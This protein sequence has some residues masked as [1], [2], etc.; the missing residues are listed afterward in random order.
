MV[1]DEYAT[2][3]PA[4]ALRPF[5]ARYTGYRQRGLSPSRHRGLPSP[6][7]TLIFTMDEPLVVAAH[8]DPRQAADRYPALIGGLHLA[9]ALI[10]HDG[11]QSGVQVAVHPV[12]CRLLLGVPAG[13][14]AGLDLP[15]SAVLG[16]RFVEEVRERL[17][18]AVDWA[19][20]FAV[21]DTMLG[22]LV[23][24]GHASSPQIGY[25]YRRLQLGSVSISSLAAAV[26]WSGRHLTDRFRAE[27]G[28]R[29]KEAARVIRFDRARRALRPGVVLAALAAEHGYA[30]QSHLVRDFRAFSGCSPSQWM[31]DEFAFVQA[32]ASGADHDGWHD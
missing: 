12:G 31:A 1:V 8:P 17:R 30:D 13:E 16:E 18:A 28:L 5:V 25:A 21:L 10:T 29:P 20:R 4:V 3:R 24:S 15:A 23:R 9:P 14:L 27:L 2:A 19:A 26:G 6:H 11:S 7:L 22:T 32:S